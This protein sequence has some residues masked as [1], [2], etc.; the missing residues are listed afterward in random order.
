MEDEDICEYSQVGMNVYFSMGHLCIVCT[1][2]VLSS[3]VY[4][5][6]VA[7]NIIVLQTCS[8]SCSG[9]KS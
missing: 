2:L 8:Q 3:L 1:V 7:N 9:G 4:Y 5:N 6:I